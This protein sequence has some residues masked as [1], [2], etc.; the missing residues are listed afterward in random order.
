VANGHLQLFARPPP[1]GPTVCWAH[2]RTKA[3]CPTTTGPHLDYSAKDRWGWLVAHGQPVNRSPNCLTLGLT[4]YELAIANLVLAK[5][6]DQNQK[7]VPTLGA[8][9]LRRFEQPHQ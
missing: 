7:S 6:P 8:E 2:C 4:D 9:T 5:G 3:R 1:A